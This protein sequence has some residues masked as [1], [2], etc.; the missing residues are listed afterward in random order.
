MNKITAGAGNGGFMGAYGL[1]RLGK[2]RVG[3]MKMVAQEEKLKQPGVNRVM[4]DDDTRMAL[5][6]EGGREEAK[7]LLE[8]KHGVGSEKVKD[9][10]ARADAIG[11]GAASKAAAWG[12]ETT[13]GK[14]RALN[15]MAGQYGRSY[16]AQMNH[17]VDDVAKEASVDADNL[18]E[19]SMYSFGG[20]GRG[21]LRQKSVGEVL[22]NKFD[23]N[24]AGTAT[25]DAITGLGTEMV[26]RLSSGTH[27]AKM[28]AAAQ[29]LAT[30]ESRPRMSEP[31]RTAWTT[32]MGSAGVDYSSQ[33]SVELQLARQVDPAAAASYDAARS[34]VEATQDA[35]RKAQREVDDAVARSGAGSGA[36]AAASAL[37]DTARANHE[38]A[39]SYLQPHQET[40]TKLATEIRATSSTYGST[41]PRAAREDV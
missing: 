17:M 31:T 26:S 33:D 38:A 36:A 37:R 12:I 25:A 7:R 13:S 4:Q 39:V 24:I 18:R 10:L 1:N 15:F 8:A 23:A 20:N 32:Q 6:A 40:L 35:L 22:D 9:A 11:F 30:E 5:M 16:S 2:S 41:T 27:A 34:R 29:M 19:E 14:G 21:D 3:N 28:Q